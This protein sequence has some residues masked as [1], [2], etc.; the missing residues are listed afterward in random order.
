MKAKILIWFFVTIAFSAKAQTTV[1]FTFKQK[2]W[3]CLPTDTIQGY[4]EG[5]CYLSKKL[6]KTYTDTTTF[7]LETKKGIQY[8][9]TICPSVK[10]FID[11]RAEQHKNF[12][13]LQVGSVTRKIFP[14]ED[15]LIAL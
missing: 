7:V 13:I 8:N 15:T 1:N 11:L 5:D 10:R 4:W 9:I 2:V 14:A 3:Y 6:S 12:M